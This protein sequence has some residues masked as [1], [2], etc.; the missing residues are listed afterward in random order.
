MRWEPTF[1]SFL[2]RALVLT[3]SGPSDNKLDLHIC[4][5]GGGERGRRI[6]RHG[7]IRDEEARTPAQGRLSIR[8]SGRISHA[9]AKGSNGIFSRVYH[10]VEKEWLTVKSQHITS[11]HSY[12]DVTVLSLLDACAANV[13]AQIGANGADLSPANI[14][15]GLGSGG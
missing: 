14:T 7:G 9:S 3:P 1:L 13:F 8:C 10:F 6:R 5:T 2:Q 11:C 12:H 15:L 4:E